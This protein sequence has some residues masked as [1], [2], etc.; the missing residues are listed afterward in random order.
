[1]SSTKQQYYQNFQY[2][3]DTIGRPHEDIAISKI[4]N[5]YNVQLVERRDDNKYDFQTSDGNTYEVKADL[6]SRTTKNFYIEYEGFKL[7]T[8]INVTKAKYHII[9]D[10]TNYYKIRTSKMLKLIE[11]NDYTV[12]TIQDSSNTKGWLVPKTDIIQLSRIL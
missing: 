2:I 8:G 4:L 3:N 11:A 10:G 5:K 9:T 12:K 6:K 7:P 1:M